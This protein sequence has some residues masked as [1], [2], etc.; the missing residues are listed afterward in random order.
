MC[1]PPFTILSQLYLLKLLKYRFTRCPTSYIH[2]VPHFK[3]G[4][5]TASKYDTEI[6]HFNSPNVLMVLANFYPDKK[7]IKR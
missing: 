3:D 7:K 6:V 2:Q 5:Y 4:F 1:L